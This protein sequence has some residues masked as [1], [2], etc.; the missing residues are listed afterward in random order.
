MIFLLYLLWW[1]EGELIYLGERII[2]SRNL[3]VVAKWREFDF[4]VW[5]LA[6]S[7]R[8]GIFFKEVGAI[9]KYGTVLEVAWEA[10]EERWYNIIFL[11][12]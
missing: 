2:I 7:R 12:E 9:W 6:I 11:A 8:D 5:D 4:Q 3:N 1:R 10:T